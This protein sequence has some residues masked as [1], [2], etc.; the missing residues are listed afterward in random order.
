MFASS[1]IHPIMVHFPIALVVFGFLADAASL[2]FRKEVC[3]SRTGFYLLASGTVMA[4][5]AWL[6]GS[7]FT[8]DLEGKA[9]EVMETHELFALITLVLLIAALVFRI[10]LKIKDKEQSRLKW[11]AFALFGLGT[12][13]V[14][15]TGFFGGTIVYNYMI[16]I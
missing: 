14:L 2:F 11:I 6:T 4:F 8:S 16:G 1:H 3:L 12:I 13:S 10:Y 5:L 9:G 15:I 7:L